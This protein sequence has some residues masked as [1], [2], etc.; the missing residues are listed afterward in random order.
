MATKKTPKASPVSSRSNDEAI[1][2][3]PPSADA[4]PNLTTCILRA[5][6]LGWTPAAISQLY[7]SKAG[8]RAL[9]IMAELI[10]E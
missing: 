1:I 7:G 8:E 4:T 6:R 10:A 2:S 3:T 9:A 5:L